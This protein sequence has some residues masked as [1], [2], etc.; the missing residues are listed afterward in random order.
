MTS[1]ANSYHVEGVRYLNVAV[2]LGRFGRPNL[3]GVAFDGDGGSANTTPEMVMVRVFFTNA[4]N[5][6]FV[7][8]YDARH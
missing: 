5:K 2:L 3:C 6:L 1:R 7:C 4:I 8:A